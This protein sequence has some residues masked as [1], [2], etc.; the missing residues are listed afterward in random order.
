[1]ALPYNIATLL[2]CFNE[3]DETPLLERAQFPSRERSK[4]G[5]PRS[6]DYNRGRK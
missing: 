5:N 1:M 4:V 3:R 2:Y 6:N